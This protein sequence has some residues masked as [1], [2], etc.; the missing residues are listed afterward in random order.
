MTSAEL[1]QAAANVV[2]GLV[3]AF[4]RLEFNIGLYLRNAIGG[5]DP[6][7]AN[8]LVSRLSFKSKMDALEEVVVHKFCAQPEALAEMKEWVCSAERVRKVRNSFV[9][10][11]WGFHVSAQQVINVEAGLPNSKPLR[12]AR[13]SLAE[14]QES[15]K[16]S[17]KF[18]GRIR[19]VESE[20][21]SLAGSSFRP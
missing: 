13:Y 14:L 12:E 20:V 5:S 16:D 11:R 2:G 9:H 18:G 6:E 4:S 7:G 1:E 8:A 15:R 21:A 3:I 17:E 10:G 19:R